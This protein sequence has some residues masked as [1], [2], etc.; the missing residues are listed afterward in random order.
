MKINKNQYKKAKKSMIDTNQHL[1]EQVEQ[2]KASNH[3]AQIQTFRSEK[4]DQFTRVE[5][6]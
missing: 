1:L 6:R 5:H 2:T 4:N 3:R